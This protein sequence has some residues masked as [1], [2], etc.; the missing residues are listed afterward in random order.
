MSE[1]G[2]GA[3]HFPQHVPSGEPAAGGSTPAPPAPG[4]NLPGRV[5]IEHLHY[6]YPDGTEALR[7]VDLRVEPGE[8][9]ALVGPNGAGKST[10]LL[11]LNGILTADHGHVSIG[12]LAVAPAS[13]RRLRAAVGLVFQDP[14]DQLF[15]PSVRED[16]AFGPIHMGV[17]PEELHHRI[18]RALAAVGMSGTEAR[19]PHHLSL[20]QRKRVAVATVLS[21]DP[22]VLAFDE[23]TAGLDPRGR[24]ELMAVMATRPETLLVSTHDLSMVAET[25]PRTVILDR[26]IVV[27]DGPTADLLADQ[28]LLEAHGLELPCRPAVSAAR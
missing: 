11:H 1:S 7:G 2:P 12:G 27:A 6:T 16:V 18:E 5:R 28:P 4:S 17:P 23:P 21:M 26:G 19:V 14:D 13:V 25:L 9:V 24:R 20:G 22:S 10:L 8:K 15:N 3:E